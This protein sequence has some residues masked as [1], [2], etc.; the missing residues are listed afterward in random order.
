MI[1]TGLKLQK[2][3]VSGKNGLDNETEES[4]DDNGIEIIRSVQIK[5]GDG[6]IRNQTGIG[7][8]TQASDH[9]CQPS[10]GD[11]E[12]SEILIPVSIATIKPSSNLPSWGLLPP[13]EEAEAEVDVEFEEDPD[14]Q[15]QT[16]VRNKEVKLDVVFEVD[17]EEESQKEDSNGDKEDILDYSSETNNE[18]LT[19]A[20]EVITENDDLLT[21][22][23]KLEH[24][25]TEGSD[26]LAEEKGQIEKPK[27][28]KEKISEGQ[29][30]TKIKATQSD[31]GERHRVDLTIDAE[32]RNEF[33]FIVQSEE[34][35][36]SEE[37]EKTKC[38]NKLL[39][40]GKTTSSIKCDETPKSKVTKANSVKQKEGN[41][42]LRA[43]N[44]V[45]K[46]PGRI[47][48]DKQTKK[49]NHKHEKKLKQQEK[50]EEAE[51][52]DDYGF[53]IKMNPRPLSERQN[54]ALKKLS[55]KD[56]IKADEHDKFE[57]VK[58]ESVPK[59]QERESDANSK[60]VTEVLSS[61]QPNVEDTHFQDNL[62]RFENIS[63]TGDKPNGAE[64]QTS[65]NNNDNTND[66]D[67]EWEPGPR[68][69][70]SLPNLAGEFLSTSPTMERIREYMMQ[71]ESDDSSLDEFLLIPMPTDFEQTVGS[72]NQP[73]PEQK[74]KL[75]SNDVYDSEENISA[76]D[77]I[78]SPN[79]CSNLPPEADEKLPQASLHMENTSTQEQIPITKETAFTRLPHPA[80]TRPD[81]IT[82][83]KNQTNV[84]G[85][86]LLRGKRGSSGG[87]VPRAIRG[88]RHTPPYATPPRPIKG[89]L[90]VSTGRGV[91]R[92]TSHGTPQTV[93]RGRG[94]LLRGTGGRGVTYT[95]L[96]VQKTSGQFTEQSW[97]SGNKCSVKDKLNNT[98]GSAPS[99]HVATGKSNPICARLSQ[100][101]GITPSR[102]SKEFHQEQQHYIASHKPTNVH[103]VNWKQIHKAAFN[104]P[105]SYS[106]RGGGN[107]GSS[108][109][110]ALQKQGKSNISSNS[111]SPDTKASENTTPVLTDLDQS[112]PPQVKHPAGVPG[113]VQRVQAHITLL[114]SNTQA[115]T[116]SRTTHA[117]TVT[118]TKTQQ[119][120]QRPLVAQ[121][122]PP[123][124]NDSET[125]Q[126]GGSNSNWMDSGV[127]MDFADES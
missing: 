82:S 28:K 76:S 63:L 56:D 84:R 118:G 114:P 39:K 103:T 12:L 60:I 74:S 125:V 23:D 24:H 80:Q 123:T 20:Y 83:Y 51:T 11:T 79:T 32:K 67:D 7:L 38:D 111:S 101:P 91:A 94:L 45:S 95:G 126:D 112:N 40:P 31:A 120:Q 102:G 69:T 89:S 70:G 72:A 73:P 21:A 33:G 22:L 104:R 121:E 14:V 78:T 41:R 49:Q 4:S 35:K 55:R 52:E 59:E 42:L 109:N 1:V 64:S 124:E 27:E 30:E 44:W 19:R 66:N 58:V 65:T 88:A 98:H 96:Y 57:E 50:Q 15:E 127:Q 113:A 97:E 54:Q 62:R 34:A 5:P 92:G 18:I 100:Q 87:G 29:S 6:L 71:D 105:S 115:T 37:K 117:F 108:R 110:P 9:V 93:P 107:R 48:A 17:S 116:S 26:P 75:N 86:S 16:E 47:S 77:E 10:S 122:L 61:F 99:Q 43:L 8:E 81:G 106:S 2:V 68:Q 46:L 90:Q 3:K 53:F 85:V 13:V 36:A 119:L 25:I